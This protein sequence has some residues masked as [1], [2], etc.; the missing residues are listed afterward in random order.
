MLIEGQSEPDDA[1]SKRSSYLDLFAHGQVKQHADRRPLGWLVL[2]FRTCAPKVSK[3]ADLGIV[4]HAD[5]LAQLWN[6][7][8][9]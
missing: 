5:E 9:K 7:L 2:G 1:G 3:A 6:Q 8:L 4:R